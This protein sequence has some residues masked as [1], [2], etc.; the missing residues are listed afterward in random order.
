MKRICLSAD[1]CLKKAVQLKKNNEYITFFPFNG[2]CISECPSQYRKNPTNTTCVPC[3]NSNDCKKLCTPKYE[4]TYRITSISEAKMLHSC[5]HINGSLTITG[6]TSNFNSGGIESLLEQNLGMIEEISGQLKI[7]HSHALVSLNFLR[8]LR[9]INGEH[10][11]SSNRP[12]TPEEQ[13]KQTL[14]VKDNMNLQKLWDWENRKFKTLHIKSGKIFFHFNPKLCMFEIDKLVQVAGLPAVS[15]LEVSKESNGDQIACSSIPLNVTVEKRAPNSIIL[16]L[17][18]SSNATTIENNVGRFMVFYKQSQ[19]KMLNQSMQYE[20]VSDCGDSQWRVTNDAE[21]N[22]SSGTYYVFLPHLEPAV[23]YMYFVR[24]LHSTIV[25]S[26]IQTVTTLPAQPSVPLNLKVNYTTSS[27]MVVS[28]SPPYHPHGKLKYYTIRGYYEPD[29]KPDLLKRDYCTYKLKSNEVL[30][31][32]PILSTTTAAPTV[33]YADPTNTSIVTPVENNCN[34]NTTDRE[35]SEKDSA[36]SCNSFEHQ[37]HF[38]AS[39]IETG[40]ENC[41]AFIYRFVD[42]KYRMLQSMNDAIDAITTSHGIEKSGRIDSPFPN[43][44]VTGADGRYD[45]FV[46]QVNVNRTTIEIENLRH[47]SEY[48]VLVAACPEPHAEVNISCSR[49]ALLSVRTEAHLQA[50]I[51]DRSKVLVNIKN[52][53]T[54]ISWEEPT[55][56]NSFVHSYVLEYRSK[57]IEHAKFTETC[58][59]L[60]DFHENNNSYTLFNLPSGHY[61]LRLRAVSLAGDGKPVYL[62]FYIEEQSRNHISIILSLVVTFTVIVII[63]VGFLFYWRRQMTKNR[64]LFASVNPRYEPVYVEDHWEV[65]RENLTLVKQL[66]RGTFGSVHEGILQPEN[67]KCAVKTTTA[68]GE[69]EN[70]IF[71]KEAT[72]MKEFHNAYHIVKLIGVVSKGSPVYVIMEL[73]EMGDLKTFL[74]R[75]GSQYCDSTRTLNGNMV[76]KM[77]AQIADGMAFLEAKKFVHRDLAA[78]NCM[79]A[80]DNTIKIGDFGLAR[81]IYETDYYRKGDKGTLPIRWMAPESIRDGIFTSSSDMWSYGI[82]LWEITTLAQMPYHPRTNEEV[83]KYVQS[84]QI[85]EVPSNA[86]EVLKPLMRLCWRWQASKRPKFVHVLK[87]LDS[88]MDASFRKVSFFH[89]GENPNDPANVVPFQTATEECCIY[90]DDNDEINLFLGNSPIVSGETA[91]SC[92]SVKYS[93]LGPNRANGHVENMR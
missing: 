8:S 75:N 89:N 33:L 80:A 18:M 12:S 74:L 84:G 37:S 67:I 23:E 83:I 5:T 28:W 1:E 3:E 51:I 65:P 32:K 15:N 77:A 41:D 27:T 87:L 54:N 64:V 63:L 85:L 68:I 61:E 91:P 13:I 88:Y 25:T 7:M 34:C 49:D 22:N 78:R 56:V 93:R 66:G 17:H 48:I 21:S 6:L 40:V 45:S 36:Q 71:L 43:K 26:P 72:L 4:A 90:T 73:M 42:A 79:V 29:R 16:A 86:H 70:T 82:V 46:L 76:L 81:D 38:D 35:N 24:S 60:Q 39:K 52:Q 9:A 2:S 58:I 14:V 59:T 19:N 50:D 47:F 30:T 57:D 31:S 92:S 44:N 55:F 69:E 10:V 62:E 11:N 20:S 53:T